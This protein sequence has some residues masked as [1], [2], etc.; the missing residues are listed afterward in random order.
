MARSKSAAD[1]RSRVLGERRPSHPLHR[2]P[3]APIVELRHA[4]KIYPGGHVGLDRATLRVDKG[5]FVFLVGPTGC[6][7]STLI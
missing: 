6:G 7:K 5:E 4:T 2:R 3:A 1:A